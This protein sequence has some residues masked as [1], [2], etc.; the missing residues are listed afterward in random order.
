[1]IEASR[2]GEEAMPNTGS[3]TDSERA[4]RGIVPG[5]NSWVSTAFMGR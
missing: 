5:L 4:G 2:N 3:S 1:V